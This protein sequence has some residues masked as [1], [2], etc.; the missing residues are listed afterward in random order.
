MLKERAA[1]FRADP[2]VAEALAAAE[3]PAL[4]TPTVADGETVADLR[5]ATYDIEAPGRPQHAARSGS[6]NSRWTTCWGCAD[7]HLAAPDRKPTSEGTTTM[8]LRP[9]LGAASSLAAAVVLACGLGSTPGSAST[10]PTTARPRPPPPPTTSWSSPARRRFRHGSIPAGVAAVEEL[11][12]EHGFTVTATED[13]ATFNDADL[14]HYEVVLWLSTTGDVLDPGQQAAFERY[15]Q[16]GG[17]Y[18]GVHAASDTEYDWPW[19]GGLVGAYFNGH[20]AQQ[21]A[22]V[23]VARAQQPGHAGA[24]EPVGAL[25]RVVQLPRLHRR[26]GPGAGDG[27][28]VD[29]RRRRDRAWARITRSPGA[30]PTTAAALLHRHGPHRASLLRAAAAVA[31]SRR[32]PAGGRRDKIPV[33]LIGGG[34]LPATY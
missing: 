8:K 17:G 32:H 33:R 18:V 26:L 34:R 9:I 19:Y 22:T 16:G 25:R 20:P 28:R 3:V 15:I 2:E 24:A 4:A 5:A 29:V 13:A 1:A 6:T 11:G 14:A 21:T 23:K 7:P 30:M 27:G 10:R 31:H 12:A